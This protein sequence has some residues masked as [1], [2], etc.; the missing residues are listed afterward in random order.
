MRTAAQI[1]VE[2][3]SKNSVSRVFSVAGESYL[4]VLDALLDAPEIEVVTNR[5]ESGASFA[6][7]SYGLL[8][9]KLGIAFVTRGP[10]A[11]NASIGV[12]AAKQSSSPMI[13]FV[14]LVSR[15]DEGKEAFQEFDLPQMFD[16]HTKWAAVIKR[17]EDIGEMVSKAFS[18]ALSG[19]P[20]PVVLGLP[21]DILSEKVSSNTAFKHHVENHLNLETCQTEANEVFKKLIKAERPLIIAG[22]SLWSDESC[23]DLKAFAEHCGLPVCASF[24]RQDLINHHSP[25]Y[26]GEL[27]TGP[28]PALVEAV[29]NADVVLLLGARINEIM[30]QGYSLF[31]EEQFLIHVY[32][33]KTVFGKAYQADMTIEA[34][35]GCFLKNLRMLLSEAND[36][37]NSEWTE[38]LRTQYEAWTHIDESEGSQAWQG[39]DMTQIFAQLRKLLPDDAIVTTDAGNFSGWCQRY[40]RYGRPGRLLAPL[41]GSMGY[42][43][44][45]ALSASLECP[46]R[47]VLGVCGDGG[48]MMTSMELATIMQSGAKPIILVCN[49]S[50]YGTIRMHQQRDF[51][52]RISGTAL[53]NPDFVEM[54]KSFGAFSVRVNHADEFEGAWAAALQADRLAVIEIVQ[55]QRQI[56]TNSRL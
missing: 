50:M 47:L 43:V 12:H 45:S 49:N 52:D 24:R 26:V 17:P 28:N 41:S 3:L 33:D 29:K 48:F 36:T 31:K 54:A 56:T 27:G 32:P 51:P 20:G 34:D 39:A 2:I 8:T 15:Q 21:E 42:A 37:K 53:T 19:R 35:A 6:A 9:G 55:D 14:G 46:D 16:S 30:T 18:V 11:C 38:G 22:G 40:L 10:G 1:L 44:P 5:Q 13:L 7:E 25:N 4:P 23:D